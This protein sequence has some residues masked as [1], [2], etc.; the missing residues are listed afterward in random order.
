MKDGLFSGRHGDEE[1]V[2][3]HLMERLP[4]AFVYKGA[5]VKETSSGRTGVCIM[6]PDSDTD[7]KVRANSPMAIGINN[8][9]HVS[10]S[11]AGAVFWRRHLG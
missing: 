5:K 6:N 1:G 10:E 8:N 4:I 11:K 7:V 3:A 2:F 9:Q